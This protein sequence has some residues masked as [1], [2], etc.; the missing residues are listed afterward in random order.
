M[1][2]SG[3]IANIPG[4]IHHGLHLGLSQG[5][6]QAMMKSQWNENEA[7]SF[8]GD[9]AQ[10]VYSSRLLGQDPDLVMHGG[11][12]TSVKLTDSNLFG[13]PEEIL[14]VKGSGWD[15][16]T[17]ET[18]GFAPVRLTAAQRL[19]TLPTLSDTAMVNALRGAMTRS[20][21][22][23]PSVE[24]ILHAIIPHRF[25]DHT[26]ADAIVTLTNNPQSDSHIKKV[27]GDRV[28]VVPYIMPGFKLARL[29]AEMYPE[30]ATSRTEGLILLKH[31]IFTFGDTARAAYE[32]M[33]DLVAEAEAYLIAQGAWD[34]AL[35]DALAVE[36]RPLRHEVA[37]L[38]RHVSRVAGRPMITAVHRDEANVAFARRLDVDAVSQ[39]GPAT[40]DHVI[41][42]KR[43]PLVGRDVDAYAAAYRAYFDELVAEIAEPITMLD[44]A[45]RVIVDPA[46]GLVTIG[47]TARAAAVAE[48]IYRHTM[49]IIVRAEQL[50][51]YKA[52]P[53]SDIFDVEY[54][55]L[56]QAKLKRG[57][58]A[59]PFTGE[60]ALVTGAASGI[61][62][63][64]VD[65]LLARGAAVVGVDIDP[66]VTTQWQRHDYV[67]I[68]ADVSDETAVAVALEQGVLTFGGL[69]ILVLNAGIFI[70]DQPIEALSLAD[71]SRIMRVNLDAN[72]LL[73]REAAPLL[74]AAPNGGRV[75]VVGSKN[76]PAPGPGAAAYSASKAALNQLARV[77]A[78]E[79]GPAGIRINSVHPNAVFDTALWTPEVLESRAAHYG[80]SVEQYK[81][82]NVLGVEVTS[83]DVAEVVAQLCSVSFSRTTGAQIPVDGGNDRVI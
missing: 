82:R 20:D 80:L 15:L 50:G 73:M 35:G 24:A 60:V 36:E 6:N 13:E 37:A 5:D 10:R 54:W 79:W 59:P 57:G 25:V 51:G 44:P 72:F 48:D 4:A 17:I 34:V 8:E 67:G 68:V 74:K 14:Y 63:A 81:A 42:T 70:A 76:V 61:G 41:R 21:S 52:L 56:E 62:R 18:A 26:H 77:A 22:P 19:A 23:T 28:I 40:P 64:C 66:V 27:F 33:I 69:D 71:W 45:P 47:P 49:T 2:D 31:G 9:L 1:A 43:L 46:L 30:R 3:Q 55:E 39:R 75:V 58:Q 16:A 7:A 12:N 83:H 53:A 78:L 38:R 32:R 11:G 65:S 29:V